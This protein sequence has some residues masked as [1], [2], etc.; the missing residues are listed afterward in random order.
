MIE[1]RIIAYCMTS[2]FAFDQR[3]QRISSSLSKENISIV[4]H[5]SKYLKE[6]N[7]STKLIDLQTRFK[8]G[9]LFYMF[10]NLKLL[11]KLWL[12]NPDIVYS[13][14]TDTLL[15]TGIYK[16]FKRK[17][18]IYDS[19]E[20]FT[21]VPELTGKTFKKKLWTWVEN[22]F[23]PKMDLCITV[24]D[25]L[26]TI[27]TKN[28]NKSFITIRNI[29]LF[30]NASNESKKEN[31]LIYQGAINE[32]RGLHC[33][34]DVMEYLEDYKLILVGDGDIK[35]ELK[36]YVNK[37]YFNDRIE[38][39]DVMLPQD[40][41][42]LT[43]T[44]IFGLNLIENT[45]LSYYYSLAN[46]FFDYLQAEVPSINMKFPEYENILKEKPFGLM[47]NE[48]DP[49]ELANAI[50]N[51]SD[52]LTYNSLVANCKKYKSEFTWE[53]EEQKL[54]SHFN[55]LVNVNK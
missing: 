40:L 55:S 39:R 14:D 11:R 2:D 4:I 26:A 27:F 7:T 9:V 21:E 42:H 43:S 48:L 25:S 51:N 19:H 29:P 24:G 53:K 52:Q 5:R 1:R 50:I 8:N 13:V 41:K 15:A 44:A 36:H 30:I 22:T 49:K 45:S 38:I 16:L 6:L 18:T 37:K 28:L 23:V 12:I 17:I 54:L 46:K 20:Y 33:A 10:F 35:N 32:G 34:I 31:L 47:I 3:M